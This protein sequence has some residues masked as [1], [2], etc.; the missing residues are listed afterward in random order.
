MSNPVASRFR[1]WFDYEQA[2]HDRAF[3][4]LESVPVDNRQGAEY[5]RAV[6]LMGHLVAARAIWLARL[7]GG[8]PL[9]GPLRPQDARLDDVRAYWNVVLAGWSSYL[10][11]LDD[12]ALPRVVEYRAGD[13]N[14]YQNTAEEILTQLF[15]HSFYH[16]G[17]IAMLV[18]A[19]GGVPAETDYIHWLRA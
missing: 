5:R 8:P 4:S 2:V 3:A 10:E 18:R 12:E 15:G 14:L 11:D 7:A 1:R 16:R 13:G 9:V 6:D 19:S 17:Q